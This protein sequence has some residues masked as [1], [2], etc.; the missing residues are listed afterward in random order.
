MSFSILMQSSFLE[1]PLGLWLILETFMD[2]KG[3]RRVWSGWH[4]LYGFFHHIFQCFRVF[5]VFFHVVTCIMIFSLW[6]KT[7]QVFITSITLTLFTSLSKYPHHLLPEPFHFPQLK[8]TIEH[9]TT[10]TPG[11]H[12][13]LYNWIWLIW[14]SHT[15]AIIPFVFLCLDCSL[16]I[17]TSMLIYIVM[18]E[19]P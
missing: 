12:I 5:S 15:S 6:L 8:L 19:L 4:F 1:P 16:N 17:L 3:T 2:L 14:I 18:W 11:N 10:S 13:L 7:F 9:L